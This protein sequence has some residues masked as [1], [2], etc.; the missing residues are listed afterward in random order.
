VNKKKK[1]ISNVV[2]EKK[3]KQN[4]TK[5]KPIPSFLSFTRNTLKMDHWPS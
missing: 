1:K 2:S 3:Q 5:Q 4:K